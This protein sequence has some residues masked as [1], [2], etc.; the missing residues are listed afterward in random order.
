[1]EESSCNNLELNIFAANEELHYSNEQNLDVLEYCFDLQCKSGKVYLI[2]NAHHYSKC[3]EAS[4]GSLYLFSFYSIYRSSL[5]EKTKNRDFKSITFVMT[6]HCSER[7]FCLQMFSHTYPAH[8]YMHAARFTPFSGRL[9]TVGG[10]D[11][12]LLQWRII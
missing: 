3:F 12:A 4:W 8:R 5:S 2:I 7:F 6:A 1:M 9:F 11:C 10:Q